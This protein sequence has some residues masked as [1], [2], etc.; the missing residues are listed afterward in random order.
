MKPRL[1][2]EWQQSSWEG[3]ERKLGLLRCGMSFKR[4]LRSLEDHRER[5]GWR[6]ASL[7][8][9]GLGGE[10]SPV[11]RLWSSWRTSLE[12]AIHDLSLSHG[13]LSICLCRSF[14]FF[15]HPIYRSV[16]LFLPNNWDPLTHAT[17]AARRLVKV[18][19]VSAP[20]APCGSS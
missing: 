3:R 2:L 16:D 4:V 11:F 12:G 18:A 9:P 17:L 19:P 15:P 1:E 14:Y 5:K 7:L 20:A 8:L 10:W 6:P 13:L